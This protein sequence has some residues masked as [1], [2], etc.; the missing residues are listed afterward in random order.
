M[1]RRSQYKLVAVVTLTTALTIALGALSAWRF[2]HAWADRPGPLSE[3][4]VIEIERGTG[5]GRLA[6]DLEHLGVVRSAA[7][8]SF[9][10]RLENAA[11]SVRAGEYRFAPA[12]A[13]DTVLRQLVDG[14]VIV[15]RLQILEGWSVSD[16]LDAVTKAPALEPT[17]EGTDVGEL[18]ARLGLGAEHPEGQFF[19]DTY[20]YVRGATDAEILRMAYKKMRSVIQTEWNG[21]ARDLPYRDQFDALVMASLVEKE[22]GLAEDRA[23]VAG[24]FVR[25]LKR[26]MRLQTDPSVIY[27]LG[28]DFDGNLTRAHLAR[29]G[30]YNTYARPGLPPTP[31][32][33]P[34][35]AAIQAALHP[36]Q[37]AFMYF[38][39]R[40]DGSSKFSATLEEHLAAVR[41]FQLGV[42]EMR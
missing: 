26:G 21:R 27:G 6:R 40:G 16:L 33:L 31:I 9:L 41:R 7:L 42:G 20:H 29:D 24:V 35:R 36:S 18:L 23:R 22:T 25:R 10:A 1:S 32:A 2:I 37:E 17:L 19:P 15:Y 8:F 14:D 11:E 38:V 34:G 5:F 13:P 39:A 28:R 3:P 30:P 4:L 12:A